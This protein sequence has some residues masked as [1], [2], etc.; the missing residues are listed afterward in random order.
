MRKMDGEH[1]VFESYL[2]EDPRSLKVHSVPSAQSG[3]AKFARTEWRALPDPLA[4]S[5][6]YLGTT[7]VEARL[8][9]G[10][11][12]QI[13]VHFAEAGHPVLGDTKYFAPGAQPPRPA[14]RGG[15]LCLHSLSL[16]F[17][18]PRTGERVEF[19]TPPPDFAAP[20]ARRQEGGRKGG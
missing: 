18:H 4:G 13:R 5:R 15:R 11:K 12:N 3:N 9:T 2:V 16:A 19:S 8:H 10:R 20:A 17:V 1:G 14:K 7:L 6:A